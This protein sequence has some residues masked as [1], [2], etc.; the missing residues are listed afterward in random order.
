[1]S[2]DERPGLCWGHGIGSPLPFHQSGN[3]DIESLMTE[4][5]W[6][7]VL[8]IQNFIFLYKFINQPTTAQLVYNL[9]HV[10]ASIIWPSSGRQQAACDTLVNGWLLS[11]ILKTVFAN[12]IVDVLQ[13]MVHKIVKIC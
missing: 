5:L 13:L 10:S 3:L 6:S 7:A 1:M 2:S 11:H 9:Q 12:T 4:L 8:L